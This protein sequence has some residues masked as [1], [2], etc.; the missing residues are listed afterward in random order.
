M[1][2]SEAIKKSQMCK[3]GARADFIKDYWVSEA[4][5]K[6]E[7]TY[8]STYVADMENTC[9]IL[10]RR[11]CKK[12]LGKVAA[13]RRR[14]NAKLDIILILS[15]LVPLAMLT[16]KEIFDCVTSAPENKRA[17]WLALAFASLTV[18]VLAAVLTYVLRSQTALAKIAKGDGR[19]LKTVDMLLD[20]MNGNLEDQREL[21]ELPSV[22]VAV[23]GD[24]RVNYDMERSGY[25]M[26]VVLDGAIS[27]EPVRTR[28]RFPIKPEF[29]HIR[30]AYVNSGF[31][32]D[33]LKIVEEEKASEKDLDIRNGVLRRYSGIA[34]NV[35]VPDGVTELAEAAFRNAKNCE[36]IVLPDTVSKIGAE[37]FSGCPAETVNI[38]NGVSYI[39]KFAFYRSGLR[40]MVIPEGVTEIAENA[41]CECY[42]LERVVVPSSCKRIGE[43]A[44]KNCTKLSE[45]V[46]NE[47]LEAISDC[48]FQ[49]CSSLADVNIP[50]GVCEIG[51]FAFEHCV[52]LDALYL[53]DTIQFMGGRA[54]DGNVNMTV[55]G[56]LGS[57]A[58]QYANE[59][60][61]RFKELNEA[62]SS[63]RHRDQSHAR[64]S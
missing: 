58:E 8:D 31:L 16:G 50:D 23:D 9:G 54:F 28:F 43:F 48:A 17:P 59:T 30:R 34:V 11:Y 6:K 36:V 18:V 25:S 41:F 29:E 49:G 32:E 22:D 61:K 57:Y 27:I 5:V 3:C 13:Q 4:C 33:N 39:D 56:K 12:C 44:F 51:N 1:Q 2:T 21:K 53:P 35:T 60:R 19:S 10:R 46:L 7:K 24:G 63:V 37:A 64:R 52:S 45:L 14:Y 55:Y 15:I 26:K 20:S 40:E 38:P 47:G 42:A 62:S